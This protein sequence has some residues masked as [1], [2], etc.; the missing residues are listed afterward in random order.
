MALELPNSARIEQSL[1]GS[2]MVYPQ[3][4]R[5]CTDQD[6]SPEEFL[7]PGHQKIYS[8]I[9]DLAE[10]GHPTDLNSIHQRLY[11]KGE[12]EAAGGLDYLLSLMDG[13]I[14]NASVPSYIETIKN[15]AQLRA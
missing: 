2:L 5:S 15:K 6:L 4:Y 3:A 11:D 1:L 9:M 10:S 14:S 7:A 12:L 8:A 13:A